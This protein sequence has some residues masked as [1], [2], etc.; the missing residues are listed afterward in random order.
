MHFLCLCLPTQSG[1]PFTHSAYQMHS[2]QPCP[3]NSMHS[4]C[5]IFSGL[6]LPH[7]PS[8]LPAPSIEHSGCPIFCALWLAHFPCT[9]TAPSIE[10]SGCLI[11][12]ALWL[13]HLPWTLSVSFSMHSGCPIYH[14]LWLSHL[15]S[16]LSAPSSM[17]SGPYSVHSVCTIFQALFLPLLSDKLYPATHTINLFSLEELWYLES[18][19][20]LSLQWNRGLGEPQQHNTGCCT[21]SVPD[22]CTG[23]I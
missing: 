14:A 1:S 2:A 8:T 11:F 7:L 17:H 13:P 3:E 9:L 12:C 21:R 6:C 19:V 10:H 20:Y 5:P 23:F 16:T 4:G 22:D 18:I 15:L